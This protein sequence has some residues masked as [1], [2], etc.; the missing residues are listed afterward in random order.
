MSYI[1]RRHRLIS[2]FRR[3]YH[4]YI[5]NST[6][7]SFFCNVSYKYSWIFRKYCIITG[8]HLFYYSYM[9]TSI[10][11]VHEAALTSPF[12]TEKISQVSLIGWKAVGM[13]VFQPETNDW[14]L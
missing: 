10:N 2:F 5:I 9:L 11:F 14:L 6:N 12:L 7:Y 3:Y 8:I 1:I 13:S 4:E